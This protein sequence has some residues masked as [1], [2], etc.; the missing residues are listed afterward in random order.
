[1]KRLILVLVALV[2]PAS[3]AAAGDL[4]RQALAGPM[5]GVEEVIF[6]ARPPGSPSGDGHWYANFGYY[7]PDANRKAYGTGGK[8]YK[9]NLRSGKLT[10]L[11]DDP[12]GCVRD[13]QVHYDGRKA[14]FSYRKAGSENYH[15]YEI[16][17]DG[18]GLRQL[19]DG[20][21]RGT[22]PQPGVQK[23]AGTFLITLISTG[24]GFSLP[25]SST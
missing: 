20:P 15:L 7:G 19:T 2:F 18:L 22:G 16:N 11:V 21:A 25:R 23:N 9:L 12:A 17:A 6:A 14:V 5:A 13:P 4:L 10:A 1:M 3:V 24:V 8:L